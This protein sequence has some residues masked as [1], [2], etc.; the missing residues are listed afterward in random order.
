MEGNPNK[1]KVID[2]DRIISY[3]SIFDQKLIEAH[4]EMTKEDIKNLFMPYFQKGSE[5]MEVFTKLIDNIKE[6]FFEKLKKKL[7]SQYKQLNKT[8]VKYTEEEKS[9]K[10]S[11]TKII[12]EDKIIQLEKENTEKA[13]STK[14][15]L[16]KQKE[17]K[18][19]LNQFYYNKADSILNKYK[20][21]V[22]YLV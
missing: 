9:T 5:E 10:E 22:F 2:L 3:R 4:S 8:V 20:Y 14:N 12:K 17:T 6:E 13:N 18:N 7:K 15:L 21:H 16:Y 11:E 19:N 1:V